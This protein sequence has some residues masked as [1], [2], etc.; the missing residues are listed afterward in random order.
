MS[1]VMKMETKGFT[2]AET[3]DRTKYLEGYPAP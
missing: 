3:A 2:R 1:S